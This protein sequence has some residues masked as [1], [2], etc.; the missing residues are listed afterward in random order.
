[1]PNQ[2]KKGKAFIGGYVSKDIADAFKA[3]A[4]ERGTT[5]KDLLEALIRDELKA[6]GS[7]FEIPL[8]CALWRI[9]PTIRRMLAGDIA[10]RRA[11][12]V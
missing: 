8:C 3:A 10:R 7:P 5:V 11:D 9:T 6:S 1:M 12:L 2:R 4:E